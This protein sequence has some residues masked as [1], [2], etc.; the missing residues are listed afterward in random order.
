M[1]FNLDM[2][3]TRKELAFLRDLYIQDEWTRRFTELVDK[4][5]DLN[6]SKNLLY[7]NSGTGGHALA[8]DEKYG[9]KTDIFANSE[10]E[11][12]LTIA[13]DKCA[14]VRSNADFSMLRFED[15][16]FDSVLA[17]ATFVSP[18][19]IERFVEGATRT[20]RPGGDVAVFLPATGS[21]G[22]IFSLLWE[23]LFNEDLGEH[24]AAVERLLSEIPTLSRL[25]DIARNSGLIDV[26]TE[27]VN[28]IFEYD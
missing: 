17:D 20:A 10:N 28:E 19:V 7:L 16:A 22:E 21:F 2:A 11:D 6:G 26:R 18:A 25:E 1:R 13:R 8:L 27:T 9:R 23:V 15:D 14:A 12:L 24:G 3:K 5:L 4:H